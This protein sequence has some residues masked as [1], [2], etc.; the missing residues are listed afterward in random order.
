MKTRVDLT[1]TFELLEA[2]D[3]AAFGGLPQ[4]PER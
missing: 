4:P 1:T 2:D 3:A